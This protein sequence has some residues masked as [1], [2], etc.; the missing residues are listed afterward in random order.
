MSLFPCFKK[1]IKIK[2]EELAF[3]IICVVWDMI[4]WAKSIVMFN[5][6]HYF[7][8]VKSRKKKQK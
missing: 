1:K 6:L 7:R 2:T 3:R 8:V 4:D 5:E